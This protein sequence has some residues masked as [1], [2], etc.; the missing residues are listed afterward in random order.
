MGLSRECGDIALQRENEGPRAV[1]VIDPFPA[2][3]LVTDALDVLGRATR[4]RFR[5]LPDQAAAKKFKGARWSL[6]ETAREPHRRPD[7]D[8]A[9]APRNRRR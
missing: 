7:R 1:I 6:L 4:N 5:Q 3:K 8:V 2:V 9:A